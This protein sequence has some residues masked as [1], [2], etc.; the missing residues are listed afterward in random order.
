LIREKGIKFSSNS[1]VLF[2]RKNF[3]V[4][5]IVQVAVFLKYP[6]SIQLQ[7]TAMNKT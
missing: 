2:C 4:I 5:L 1:F 7:S 3:P 6:E